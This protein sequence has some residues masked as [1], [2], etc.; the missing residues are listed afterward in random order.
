MVKKSKNE[1]YIVDKIL[2]K[3][4]KDGVIHYRVHWKGYKDSEDTW[5]PIFSFKD[6][7]Y[8]LVN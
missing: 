3:R 8:L 7:E 4:N 6:S 1:T 5:E 2:G